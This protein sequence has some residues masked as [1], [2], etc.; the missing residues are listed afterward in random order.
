MVPFSACVNAT[1]TEFP[2][3]LVIPVMTGFVPRTVTFKDASENTSPA[4]LLATIEMLYAVAFVNPLIVIEDASDE[5]ASNRT[6]EPSN[7]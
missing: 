6:F 7:E 5:D 3:F 1:V 4:G 2:M